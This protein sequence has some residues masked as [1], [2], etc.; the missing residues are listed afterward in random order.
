MS[1]FTRDELLLLRNVLGG[2]A[3]DVRRLLSSEEYQR[4]AAI[5]TR[6]SDYNYLCRIDAL[7]A[8]VDDIL[9]KD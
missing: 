3:Y 8:R 2:R 4:S 1:E 6:K 7:A 5:E 9:L